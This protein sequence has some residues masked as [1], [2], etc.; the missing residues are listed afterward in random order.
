MQ[1]SDDYRRWR[2]IQWLARSAMENRT[3]KVRR[4]D[5]SDH[6]RLP[7]SAR[8]VEMEQDR[9]SLVLSHHAELAR[10][11]PNEPLGGCRAGRRNQDEVLNSPC[12]LSIP[13]Q[14]RGLYDWSRSKRLKRPLARPKLP[15]LAAP[16]HGQS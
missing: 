8:H 16:S 10:Q 15:R 13:R 9:A 7:L 1:S 2:R 3:A 4:R 12:H 11:A 5:W 14:S 6:L